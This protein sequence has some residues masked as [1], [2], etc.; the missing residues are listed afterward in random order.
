MIYIIDANNLAGKLK[1]LLDAEFDKILIR[2]IKEYKPEKDNH[3]YLV[4]DSNDPYGD[5]YT[6]EN[7]TVI[8]TPRDSYY[9]SA[10]DKVVELAKDLAKKANDEITLISDDIEIKKAVENIIK[11]SNK[12][13][14]IIDA[15]DFVQ[16]LIKR[17]EKKNQNSE[18]DD[19]DLSDEDKKKINRELLAL[20]K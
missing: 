11:E 15:T 18:E 17:L 19:D 1:I 4:F 14:I 9:K 16:R 3:F 13:I 10:D 8:R 2:Y 12:K 20:W 6:E 7:I 5:K